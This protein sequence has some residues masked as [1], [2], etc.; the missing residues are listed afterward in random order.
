[1]KIRSFLPEDIPEVTRMRRQAFKVSNWP[2]DDDLSRYIHDV[3]F[4][5]PWRNEEPAGLVAIDN[6]GSVIG[7]V[8]IIPRHMRI[9]ER[10]VKAAVATQLM[11]SADHRGLAGVE[12]VRK[13]FQLPIDLLIAD[14]GSD[15]GVRM[16]SALGGF[17]VPFT[18]FSWHRALRPVTQAAS[19]SSRQVPAGM[20][21]IL[22][23]VAG[24]FLP[25]RFGPPGRP[26]TIARPL[27]GSIANAE[28]AALV[29]AR[30]LRPDYGAEGLDWLLKQLAIKAGAGG[31][32]RGS[33]VTNEAG[34]VLGWYV[35]LLRGRSASVLQVVSK[36]ATTS[37][38]LQH[39]MWDA[40]EAGALDLTGRADLSYAAEVTA[41]G[42]TFD[43]RGSGLHL[44]TRDAQLARM[45]LEGHALITTL[46]GEWW[47]AF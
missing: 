32:V 5:N 1:M 3:F 18:R 12:L 42:G 39:L 2:A 25:A 34:N 28:L 10:T 43:L 11:V 4:C 35:Y 31:A 14:A 22:D 9:G 40:W 47:L 27:D 16:W 15:A 36:P 7:F 37:A 24:R 45:A 30:T 44:H 20:L 38:V 23:R 46:E 33:L 26:A 19:R 41:A 6:E 21:G 8:G 29:G 17:A 13:L